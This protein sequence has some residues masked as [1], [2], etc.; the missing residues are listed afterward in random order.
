M[1]EEQAAALGYFGDARRAAIGAQLIE[2]VTAARSLVIR[3]LG[4]TRA[5][6]LAI[7]CFLSA[8]SVTCQEMLGTLAGRTLA[9]TGGRRIVLAPRGMVLNGEVKPSRRLAVFGTVVRI[10]SARGVHLGAKLG[11]GSGVRLGYS[12]VANPLYVAHKRVTTHLR[13]LSAFCQG[14]SRTGF[15]A[16]ALLMAWSAVRPCRRPV[17]MTEAAA[18]ETSAPHFERKHPVTLR[19]FTD[20]RRAARRHCWYRARRG[21]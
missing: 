1:I 7:H 14:G 16:R 12:Q 11:R 18:A 6:Q 5:G 15:P 3:K 19:K 13:L 4:A 21:G 17:A 2:R 10:T 20:G 9:A 8:P